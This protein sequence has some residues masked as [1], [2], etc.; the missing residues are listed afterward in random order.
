MNNNNDQYSYGKLSNAQK[1]DRAR[2][3]LMILFILA[4]ANVFF[5][6]IG[7]FNFGI[8][9]CIATTV[10]FFFKA[11]EQSALFFALGILLGVAC[12]SPLVVSFIFSKK[13]TAYL[14]FGFYFV[15]LDS[16]FLL[17]DVTLVAMSD[18]IGATSYL[19]DIAFHAW[20]IY[21]L[22]RGIAVK[23]KRD[24]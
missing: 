16:L 21:T 20:M 14:S 17:A 1:Y 9:S 3:S 6:M 18:P 23:D 13:K 7:N 24:E 19:A 5:I 10:T 12:T 8:S 4:F 22:V 2:I 15:C 11:R